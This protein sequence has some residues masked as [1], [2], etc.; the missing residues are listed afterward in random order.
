M[1]IDAHRH[2]WSAG[3]RH[4]AAFAGLP[5]KLQRPPTDFNWEAAAQETIEEMD[6]AGVD[7]TVMIVAD[8]GLCLGEATLSI[9]LEN[10]Y[11]V[12]AQRRYPDRLTA[13]FGIDPQ[14]PGAADLFE[15]AIREGGVRGLKLHPTTGFY[16]HDRRCYPLYELCVAHDLPVLFHTGPAF[17]PRL[18]SRHCHPL[19]YDQVAAEFPH[20]NMIMAHA[21]S[22]YW[23]N[24]CLAVADAHINMILE[25]SEWQLVYLDDPG[26]M[27][28]VIDRMR[29]AIGM[30]RIIWASDFP[31]KRGIMPL[32]EWVDIFRGLPE[33]GA[34]YGSKFTAAEVDGFLGVNAA[35]I[36]KLA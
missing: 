14:R 21:G 17:H 25:L 3:Q 4:R 1:I 12:D 28:R 20:L 2:M 7:K 24:D 11:L 26:H 23:W 18:Y 5:A 19:E 36:L 10:R 29:N 6:A 27:V 15:R 8:F 13:Y 35:R 30:E 9:E 32:K 16:P 31:G 33:L 22:H 34:K